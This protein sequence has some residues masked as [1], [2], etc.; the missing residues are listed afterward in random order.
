MTFEEFIFTTYGITLEDFDN[1]PLPTQ[2]GIM[3][4]YKLNK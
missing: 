1:L 4:I 2:K 3:S